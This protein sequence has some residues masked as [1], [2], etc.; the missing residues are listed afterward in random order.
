MAT[1]KTTVQIVMPAM[2]ESVTE[3]VV[4]GWLKQVGE[5]VATDE[6]LV[7]ISTDKVDAGPFST[8]GVNCAGCGT[9]MAGWAFAPPPLANGAHTVSFR[10]FDAFSRASPTLTRTIVVDTTPPVFSSITAVAGSASVAATFTE[11]PACITVNS[12][13]FTATINGAPVAV[14]NASCTPGSGTLTLTLA[15]A[16]APGAIVAVTLSGVISDQAGNVVAP[17]TWSDAA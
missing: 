5:A 13:D 4:L 12:F 3:G 9:L 2:G 6:P 1:S 15:S 7:E 14:N 16:P 11:A 10:A 8:A 17:M